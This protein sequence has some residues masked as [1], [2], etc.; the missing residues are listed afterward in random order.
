MKQLL[1]I[2]LLFLI[3]KA[4]SSQTEEVKVK[5]YTAFSTI[6]IVGDTLKITKRKYTYGNTPSANPTSVSESHSQ[7]K[8]TKEELKQVIDLISRKELY[9]LKNEYGVSEDQR[10]YP[11]EL[12]VKYKDKHKKIIYRSSPLTTEKPP[13]LFNKITHLLTQLSEKN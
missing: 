10:F 4:C 7:R 8:L 13:E 12:E 6:E 11:Y 5:Y 9:N 1:G 2:L 3:T